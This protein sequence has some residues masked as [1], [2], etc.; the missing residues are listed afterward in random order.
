M[1]RLIGLLTCVFLCTGG[2]AA[3]AQQPTLATV[4]VYL[5]NMAA[6][7]P[8]EDS[9]AVYAAALE[10]YRRGQTDHPAF[11]A[12]LKEL[13][14]QNSIRRTLMDIESLTAAYSLFALETHTETQNI[15][16]LVVNPGLSGWH[17]PYVEQQ[18]PLGSEWGLYDIF[19]AP[20]EPEAIPAPADCVVGIPCLVWLRMTDTP[21]WVVED[22]EL[23]LDVHAGVSGL[24]G[25]WRYGL[26]R[27][28]VQDGYYALAEVVKP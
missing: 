21:A 9:K 6:S 5:T 14:S 17:G 12:V 11:V 28:G 20:F 18:L 13:K 19:F 25:A 27:N 2:G 26:V 1:R 8:D 15:A 4:E 16:D 3:F 24:T 23:V 10:A 22:V 7:A